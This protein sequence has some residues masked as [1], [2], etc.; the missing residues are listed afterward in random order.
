MTGAIA[1]GNVPGWNH[2][3]YDRFLRY[4]KKNVTHR[5]HELSSGECVIRRADRRLFAVTQYAEAMHDARAVTKTL[6]ESVWEQHFG[7]DR[8]LFFW[9]DIPGR[10]FCRY[11]DLT[12]SLSLHWHDVLVGENYRPPEGTDEFVSSIA[13]YDGGLSKRIQAVCYTMVPRNA[14]L[15]E[16]LD[17]VRGREKQRQNNDSYRRY[18]DAGTL[19]DT[20][21]SR[22]IRGA[23]TAGD[24]YSYTR[25]ASSDGYR[26]LA[27]TS[28]R[29]C[30]CSIL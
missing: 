25:G 18:V 30:P 29:P 13:R 28:E 15:E 3:T 20:L 7:S 27:N 11:E 26:S 24:A 21:P 22:P 16:Y 19:A 4:L 8:F 23:S 6:N 9:S 10:F 17:W 5:Q 12:E 2:A 1:E 14:Y